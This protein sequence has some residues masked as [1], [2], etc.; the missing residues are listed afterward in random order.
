MSGNSRHTLLSLLVA[1]LLVGCTKV[2]FCDVPLH[3]HTGMVRFNYQ[4]ESDSIERPDSMMV[5][6]NR[7]VNTW[8]AVY[9][10]T[11]DETL[12]S[13][14]C[15]HGHLDSGKYADDSLRVDSMGLFEVKQGDYQFVAFSG[16]SGIEYFSYH[17][18]PEYCA[19]DSVHVDDIVI[20]YKEYRLS[21]PATGDLSMGWKNF[22]PYSGY[23]A[24]DVGPIY[25]G[26]ISPLTVYADDEVTVSFA[27]RSVTQKIGF[28]FTIGKD[29]VVVV[30]SV[31]AEVSGIPSKI[32]LDG[33]L[34]E[35]QDIYGNSFID[36]T[37]KKLFGV[38]V[39]E[40][41]DSIVKCY[42]EIDVI[43]LVSNKQPDYTLGAGILQLAVYAHIINEDGELDHECLHARIN[44]YHSL[45]AMSPPLL[46][47]NDEGKIVH[48]TKKGIVEISH[49]LH[50]N[51]DFIVDSGERDGEMDHWEQIVDDI[52]IDI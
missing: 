11:A 10:T 25:V 18:L 46:R 9:C 50:I 16:N 27:P 5:L 15:H 2:D 29:S 26:D 22:N 12:N 38:R 30:D 3:P 17:N 39:E 44:L 21:H 28:S 32:N 36:Y 47:R 33:T 40:E 37:Y 42:G 24:S 45:A 4:W 34:Y 49:S 20:G 31:I 52:D 43:G 35:S 48:G 1:L 8:H 7:I 13:G 41:S 6:A 23:I 14:T 51:K 19:G